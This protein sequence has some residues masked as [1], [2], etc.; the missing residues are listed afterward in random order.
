MLRSPIRGVLALTW[1]TSA[2]AP[3]AQ[4]PARPALVSPTDASA[5]P[6]DG[7]VGLL[8]MA[9]GGGP[10]WNRSV[11]DML[12]PVAAETPTAVAF[13]M[14]DP[15]T[16]GAALDTLRRA[17]VGRVAVV[18]LFV[19][20]ASFLDQTRYL[21]GLSSTPPASF[22]PGHGAHGRDAA[23]HGG[24]VAAEPAPIDHGL[25]VATHDD[26]LMDS[27]LALR[28]MAER[29]RA[30]SRNP[31]GESVM[32][33]A[34]G[35]GDDHE[36]DELLRGMAGIADELR[37]DG[38][39]AAR[40]FTLRE[41]WAEKRAVAEREMRAFAAAEA[42]VGRRVLVVP[43]RLSGFGPYAN[44]LEGLQYTAG[45]GLLPHALAATWVREKAAQVVCRA[46]WADCK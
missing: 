1:I 18:R 30:L 2:C 15:H 29:A 6:A 25:V 7:T 41:D 10:E 43:M 12:A 26:G 38:F 5:A 42:E 27:P 4:A 23:P 8:V 16:L 21:L 3:A 11:S 46:G 28:I 17:G 34:H 9:H 45:E 33:V 40:A 20:G 36:N 24:G 35:S 22:I 14:A 13:G 37:A 31:S 32:I 39:A 19:S 44:V